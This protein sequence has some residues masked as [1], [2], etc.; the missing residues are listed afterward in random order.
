MHELQDELGLT[1]LFISHNLAVVRP[2]ADRIVV[3][4]LSHQ[5]PLSPRKDVPFIPLSESD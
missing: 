4:Y 3:M 2:M 1:Y 5:A